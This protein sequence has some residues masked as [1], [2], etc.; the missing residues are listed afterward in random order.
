MKA[1]LEKKTLEKNRKKNIKNIIFL[2]SFIIFLFILIN[3]VNAYKK[4]CLMDG[5]SVPLPPKPPI[6]TCHL[7]SGQGYCQ[8]CTT[9]LLNPTNPNKC[10][11]IGDCEYL[12]S[13][14]PSNL[15]LTV[16]INNYDN[17]STK[18]L[19]LNIQTSKKAKIEYRDNADPKQQWISLCSNC[20]NHNRKRSFKEGFNNITIRA[21][22]SGYTPVEETIVFFVDSKKPRI[23]KILPNNN[24]YINNGKFSITYDEDY[25]KQISLYI[26][27][28][29]I[30]T[31]TDC[32]SGKKQECIFNIDLTPYNNQEISYY[33]KVEDIAQSVNSKTNKKITVDLTNPIL[34]VY[35]PLNQDYSTKKILF[36]MTTDNKYTLQYSL[37]NIK[38]KTLCSNCN[39]YKSYKTFDVGN[40]NLYLQAVDKAGNV[41]QEII[42]FNVI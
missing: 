16:G 23:T 8:I 22:K 31:K 19:S 20:D 13:Q 6:Y 17:F 39:K 34:T 30:E 14:I 18:S 3:N 21:S 35:S 15:T 33:F 26:N 25:L 11:G 42:N 29:F 12:G 36:N 27:D 7:S 9:D 40:Y 10:A 41:D 32:T 28:N 1:F 2:L 5:E 37:D 4:L 24:A 38:Y